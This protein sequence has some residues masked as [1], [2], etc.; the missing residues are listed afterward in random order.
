DGLGDACESIS[1]WD[2][3]GDVLDSKGINHLTNH[4]AVFV[5]GIVCQALNFDGVNDYLERDTCRLAIAPGSFTV[6]A[7]V[8]PDE[9]TGGWRTILEY[10]RYDGGGPATSWFGIW[11]NSNGNFHFRVGHPTTIDS[12]TALSPDE[13]YLLTATYNAVDNQAILYINGAYDNFAI[14]SPSYFWNAPADSSISIGRRIIDGEYFNGAIDEVMIFDRA[15]H[16]TEINKILGKPMCWCVNVNPR[17]CYGDAD[18]KSQGKKKYWVSTNDL[19]ILIAA[20]NKPLAEIEGKTADGVPL[21][22]ADFDHETQG[23]KKYRVSTNDLDILV[24]NWNIANKPDPD[25]P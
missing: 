14:L 10:D 1:H 2:F 11:L 25:C 5:E 15:L 18:G 6:F 24:S 13:W 4:G 23:K 12:V 21:I 19:D 3:D 8:K 9:V 20:W 17:Q 22:C 16:Q 7:W